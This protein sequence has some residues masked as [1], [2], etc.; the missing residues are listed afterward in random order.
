MDSEKSALATRRTAPSAPGKPA[1]IGKPTSAH[2]QPE[3]QHHLLW[4]GKNG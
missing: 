2:R 3:V 4:R 1:S